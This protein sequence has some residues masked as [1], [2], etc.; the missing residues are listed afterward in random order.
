MQAVP[1]VARTMAE[2]KVA[3]RTAAKIPQKIPQELQLL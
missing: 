3:M 2:A 1:R